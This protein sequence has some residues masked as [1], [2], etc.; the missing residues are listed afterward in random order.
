LES[1]IA[2][3]HRDPQHPKRLPFIA[4]KEPKLAEDMPNL[5]M[6]NDLALSNLV[7]KTKQ[8]ISYTMLARPLRVRLRIHN[9]WRIPRF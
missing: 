9:R 6:K 4:A 8:S 2:T 5:L 7:W 3:F 1:I